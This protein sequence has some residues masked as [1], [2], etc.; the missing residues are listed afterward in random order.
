MAKET[1]TTTIELTPEQL[2][3]LI[4]NY[5]KEKKNM[6]VSNVNFRIGLTGDDRF[7]SSSSYDLT[8]IEVIN[9]I[10]SDIFLP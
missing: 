4:K 7:H 6:D 9:E 3:T 8:K 2:K 1:I 5:F 10:K